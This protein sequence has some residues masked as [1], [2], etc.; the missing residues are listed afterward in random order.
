MRNRFIETYQ[1]EVAEHLSFPQ[2]FAGVSDVGWLAEQHLPCPQCSVPQLPWKDISYQLDDRSTGIISLLCS[3]YDQ[4][5]RN[6]CL[7]HTC[8][9]AGFLLDTAGLLSSHCPFRSWPTSRCCFNLARALGM[10]RGS[11]GRGSMSFF[12]QGLRKHLYSFDVLFQQRL[13]LFK[14]DRTIF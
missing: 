14:S 13:K 5:P 1:Q 3:L 2:H 4:C 6:S 11:Q 10:E 8:R 7:W 12:Y 9:K